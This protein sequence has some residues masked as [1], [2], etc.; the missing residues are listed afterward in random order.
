MSKLFNTVLLSALAAST[1]CRDT[2][3]PIPERVGFVPQARHDVNPGYPVQE[4]YTAQELEDKK[5]LIWVQT[6]AV[7]WFTGNGRAYG[8]G[9]SEFFANSADQSLE[10][11]LFQGASQMGSTPSQTKT[12]SGLSLFGSL[13]S[14]TDTTQIPNSV[15][16]G[17]T[18]TAYATGKARYIVFNRGLSSLLTLT[19]KSD[20]ANGNGYMNA[21]PPPKAV[22]VA[23]IGDMTGKDL[24]A[25]VPTGQ[26]A[27]FELASTGSGPGQAGGPAISSYLWKQAGIQLA[28]SP[29][30]TINTYSSTTYSLT[31]TDA[32]GGTATTSGSLTLQPMNP[33]DDPLTDMEE[34]DCS[35]CEEGYD[36]SM[37][38][39]S[40]DPGWAHG[41][42]PSSQWVCYVTDW[43]E[44]RG[45]QW[46]YT[47]TTLDYCTLE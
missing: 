24:V 14:V 13:G 35:W 45:G 42:G 26:I 5:A 4:D 17:I 43:Y 39:S 3:A 11:R 30:A 32:V 1:A 8:R 10:M 15:T 20:P 36:I 2:Q 7:A 12:A 33:C 16:C 27:T 9:H 44:W 31:V 25:T 22:S 41:G 28:T 19:E 29:S 40:S 47:D 21:C 38:G 46:V 37:G 6:Q 18:A 34:T 23:S